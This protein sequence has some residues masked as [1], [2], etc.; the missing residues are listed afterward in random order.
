M[1]FI[2]QSLNDSFNEKSVLAGVL[3]D[4]DGIQWVD[5]SCNRYK[6]LNPIWNI[7]STYDENNAKTAIPGYFPI[8]VVSKKM[9]RLSKVRSASIAGIYLSIK[10]DANPE[11]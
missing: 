7:P 10:L 6:S 11:S 9:V 8:E 1:H 5:T 2:A 3:N 4:N